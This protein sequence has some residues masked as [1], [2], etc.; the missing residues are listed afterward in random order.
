MMRSRVI[1]L[2]LFLLILTLPL[3]SAHYYVVVDSSLRDVQEQVIEIAEV[4]NGTVVFENLSSSNLTFLGENDTVLFVINS[5]KFNDEFVYLIYR[6]LDRNE[7]GIYDPVVGFL[8]VK[9]HKGLEKWIKSLTKAL[10]N[11]NSRALFI[12]PSCS[13]KMELNGNV[14]YLYDQYAT[15]DG[16]LKHSKN[17]SLIWIA[18][19]GDPTGV[20]L[21]YWRFDINHAGNVSGKAFIF[22][23]CS[24]GMIWRVKSPLTLSLLNNGSPTVVAS[25]DSGGVSYLP[26]KY[27]L[28]NY[29]LGKLVQ[30]N[31]AYFVKI[32]LPPKDVLF[33]DPAFKVGESKGFARIPYEHVD[34]PDRILTPRINGY[35]YLPQEST[36]LLLVNS[37]SPLDIWRSIVTENGIFIL[38][39]AFAAVLIGPNLSKLKKRDTTS[40]LIAPLLPLL[41][42]TLVLD[43]IP[44]SITF[45]I[46][47]CWAILTLAT[48]KKPGLL[49]AALFA[50]IVLFILFSTLAG[51]IS[52]KYSIFLLVVGILSTTLL[53]LLLMAAL[54]FVQK[55][56]IQTKNERVEG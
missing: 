24:V 40:A 48:H 55:L 36:V 19:H 11:R 46:Y 33:G 53:W 20:N 7:D 44:L 14:Y 22:E 43:S 34:Y 27:W 50:P 30:I 6:K 25:I 29:T 21:L 52:L 54:L 18:G 4:H 5:S 17:V 39:I 9:S 41:L 1:F 28:S 31:N 47:I 56:T 51:L 26:Q 37:I 32:G 23:A 49:F 13:P 42:L 3:I 38:I 8:P 10:K 2:V 16:Y 45:G 15:Y 35:A 12:C